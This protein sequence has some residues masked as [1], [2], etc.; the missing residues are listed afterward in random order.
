[1]TIEA[2]GPARIPKIEAYFASL[3]K[4]M[5]P[6]AALA[7]EFLDHSRKV[8]A[9]LE[10]DGVAESQADI[11]RVLMNGFYHLYGPADWTRGVR[12]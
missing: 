11:T 4:S 5:S 2:R 12:T 8:A 6:G 9:V 10:K 1:M 7:R 3:A